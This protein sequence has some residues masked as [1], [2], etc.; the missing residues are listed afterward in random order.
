MHIYLLKISNFRGI[1]ELEWTIGNNHV[2][3]LIGP[4]DSTKSTILDAVEYVLC[5]RWDLP[6]T[7]SDFYLGNTNL[8]ICIEATVGD[9]PNELVS[10][11]K[12]GLDIRGWKDELHDEPV[13]DDKH[14]LTIRLQ[15]QESLQPEW[16]VINDRQQAP[17]PI[18]FS[19]REKLGMIRLGTNVERHLAWGRNSALTKMT[20]DAKEFNATLASVNR[21]A[22]NVI[23][24]ANL[25]VLDIAA[26]KAQA[27]ATRFGYKPRGNFHPSFDP[28]V[29]FTN[30]ATFSL[31]DDEVP[32]RQFGLGSRKI[33]SLALQ[34]E[35]VKTGA[36]ALVDEVEHG[37][38][39]HRIRHLL[40]S[41][42]PQSRL[43]TN[44]IGQVFFTTHS[45]ITIVELKA[46]ELYVVRSVDGKTTV[47]H[48]DDSLQN[49]V[50]KVPDAL[51]ARKIVV[52][53]GSTEWGISRSLDV[54]WTSA[55][56]EQSLAYQGAV[57]IVGK[58][59]SGSEA[60][61]VAIRLAELGYSVLLWRDSDCEL[62]DDEKTILE[63]QQVPIVQWD[64]SCST[65]QRVCAD[66]PLL[67]LQ[68]LINIAIV[69]RGSESICSSLNGIFGGAVNDAACAVD[70]LKA[71]SVDEGCI[72]SGI[73]RAST[74]GK[75]S[76]AWF[77]RAD[78]GE[79]VGKVICSCLADISTTDLTHKLAQIEGWVYAN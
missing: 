24:K 41:L 12:Y 74:P 35:A 54:A 72:R 14:V 67:K 40:R 48:V 55:H 32:L 63:Q 7:D 65:E 28:Q 70:Q 71:R 45:P 68:E 53:E 31:H 76:R 19:D 21:D 15:V 8:P 36:I 77:K 50:R 66:L 30:Q 43:T 22:R 26:V 75:S 51:L 39:P 17:K 25:D 73:A 61:K 60:P 9:M 59:G 38:E 27:A 10:D 46:N 1:R 79:E 2:V 34:T 18:K 52:C 5:P 37:L 42:H 6:F 64:N 33:L 29:M 3:C 58:E 16:F 47:Q 62:P 23:A 57:F 49:I 56:S 13:Q 11:E 44:S 78:L 20:G 69:E 4:G